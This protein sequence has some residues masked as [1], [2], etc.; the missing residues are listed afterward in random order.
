MLDLRRRASLAA[1]ALGLGLL[2]ACL[3]GFDRLETHVAYDPFT[4]V[5]HVERRFVGIGPRFLGCSDAEGCAAALQRAKAFVPD[6]AGQADRL[7]QRLLD[8]GAVEIALETVE[9]GDRVDAVVRYDAP[10]GSQAAEDTF[11][12]AE[13]SGKAADRGSYYLVA[14]AQDALAVD[15]PRGSKVRKVARQSAVGADWSQQWVLPSKVLEV[16]TVLSVGQPSSLFAEITGLRSAMD[17]VAELQPEPLPAPAPEP[18]PAPAP[19]PAPEPLPAPA[20]APAPPPAPTPPPLPP[21]APAPAPPPDPAPTAVVRPAPEPRPAPSTWL[22]PDPASP[23]RTYTY[24][25]AVTGALSAAAA[26]QATQPLLPR[27]A[28]CYQDR[29]AQDP[30][31]EGSLFVGAVVRAD[32]FVVSTSV[33]GQL[34]DRPL[35]EC[36]ERATADWRFPPWGTGEQT[37]EI[38]LPVVF[39][40]EEPPPVRGK[41]KR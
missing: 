39:H 31:V 10:L 13:W 33:Y 29:H 20:P 41:R 32:G 27:I 4:Q 24:D 3:E 22:A 21:P 25:V 15:A 18:V 6:G 30:S 38:A 35:S 23:A 1:L 17:G 2:T 40:V 19:A 9:V 11:V 36:L 37:S 7:L 5:F 14:D 16:H 8:S 26:T 12:H 28:R 34:R